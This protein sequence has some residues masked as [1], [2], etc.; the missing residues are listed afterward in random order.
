MPML[1]NLN[2]SYIMR[3]CCLHRSRRM[4]FF[5]LL[6]VVDTHTLWLFYLTI[7]SCGMDMSSK[8]ARALCETRGARVDI[9]IRAYLLHNF[10]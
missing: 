8:C 10:P 9:I 3:H 7:I 4:D 1:F 5:W 6:V 2:I